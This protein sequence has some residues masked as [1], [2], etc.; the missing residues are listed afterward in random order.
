MRRAIAAFAGRRPTRREVIAAALG[1]GAAVPACAA[2]PQPKVSQRAAAYQDTPKG[3]FS[4]AAC[5]FF[6]KPRGCK[7]VR[8]DINPTGWCKLFDLAD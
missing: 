8:G 3:M 6:I 4:C 5:T 7:V 2:E 1:H